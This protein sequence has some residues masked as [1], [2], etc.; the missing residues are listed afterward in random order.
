VVVIAG[1]SGGRT[2]RPRLFEP[3]LEGGEPPAE[4]GITMDVRVPGDA[5]PEQG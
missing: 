3:L 1:C 2:D 4:G 5:G